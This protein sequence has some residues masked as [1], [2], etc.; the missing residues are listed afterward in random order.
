MRHGAVSY[1]DGDGRPVPPD[2]V[3]LTEEG[4]AQAEAARELLSGIAFDRVIASGLPRTMETA[5]AV[6]PGREV[7]VW[8]DLRE[9][10]G[11]PL[12]SI[13]PAELERAFVHAFRGVVP[14]GKRFL[15]GETIGELFDRV[16]PALDRLLADDAWDTV[17]LVLHG[18]V[19]RAILSHALTGEKMFLGHFE[20]A[21]GC[22]NVLDVGD[23]WIVRAVNVS[24]PDLAHRTTRQTTME[25]YW[26]RFRGLA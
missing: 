22:V 18:A 26:E 2:T 25:G 6:A 8:P 12:S 1:F 21:P 15:G 24:P 19:N 16:V 20:Q 5:A 13:P 7:E 11:G 14:N 10:R 4:R 17:L 9:L 3:Q 23:D